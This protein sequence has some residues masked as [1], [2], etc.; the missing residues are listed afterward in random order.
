[1]GLVNGSNKKNAQRLRKGGVSELEVLTVLAH[2]S[3]TD[4]DKRQA[5]T[6]FILRRWIR[7]LDGTI[8]PAW[9]QLEEESLRYWQK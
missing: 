7:S 1:M 2:P 9:K 8:K 5:V 6:D 4:E 3:A